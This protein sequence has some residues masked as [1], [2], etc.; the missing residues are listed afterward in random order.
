MFGQEIVLGRIL[1]KADSAKFDRISIMTDS[2]ETILWNL[3]KLGQV[4][5]NQSLF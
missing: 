5:P 1:V 2:T 4:G 3:A